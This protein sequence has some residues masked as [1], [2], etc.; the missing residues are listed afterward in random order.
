MLIGNPSVGFM[1]AAGFSLA[2]AVY[3][4]KSFSVNSQETSP[5][6]VAFS[7]DGTKM[8]VAGVTNDTVYQYTLSTPFDVSTATYASKSMAVG[9][10]NPRALAFKPD[11]TTLFVA[12]DAG[13]NIRQYTL[14]TPW[15]ISTGS[16][17]SKTF[18]VTSQDGTPKG[19]WVNSAGTRMYI[20]GDDNNTVYQYTIGT[21]WDVSTASYASKSFSVASQNTTPEGL[22]FSP[23]ES[24]MFVLSDN[25]DAVHQYQ[26]ATPGD[27][28]TA[29]YSSISLS[30]GSQDGTPTDLTFS[31]SGN[32]LYVIGKATNSVFQYTLI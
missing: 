5:E 12:V 14:S 31:A 23:D 7:V 20:S 28:S 22:T 26:L 16:Y 32:A 18:S 30:V 1:G 29:S 13:Q 6:A 24:K 4:S 9:V 8:Y 19:L 15:D 10:V 27:V 25:A 11:G 17:A 3:A 2:G 21:P